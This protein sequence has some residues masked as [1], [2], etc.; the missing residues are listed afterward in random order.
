MEDLIKDM[1]IT[2]QGIHDHVKEMNVIEDNKVEVKYKNGKSLI[3]NVG[4][5]IFYHIVEEI[6]KDYGRNY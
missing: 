4:E 2:I 5:L 3:I 1:E 6:A